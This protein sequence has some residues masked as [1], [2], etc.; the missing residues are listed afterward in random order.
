MNANRC[1]TP[2]GTRNNR[3]RPTVSPTSGTKAT[4]KSLRKNTASN[5][6]AIHIRR[7]TSRGPRRSTSRPRRWMSTPSTGPR[8]RARSLHN[9]RRAVKPTTWHET[10]GT[11]RRRTRRQAPRRRCIPRG[12][13]PRRIPAVHIRRGTTRGPRKSTS[14]PRRWTSTP[15]TATRTRHRARTC[16]IH[17]AL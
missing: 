6:C 15:S 3:Y 16:T 4:M 17:G 8:H 12:R 11:D 9:T 7:E 2:P 1:D 5:T 14:S 13:T 10:I